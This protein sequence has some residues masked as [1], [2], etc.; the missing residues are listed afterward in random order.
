MD[1]PSDELAIRIIDR[2]L[3]ARL[4]D[5]SHAVRL[6]T[7]IAQGTTTGAE[8]RAAVEGAIWSAGRAERGD[9]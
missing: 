9:E 3:A 5:E 2:L 7:S 4:I 8:W 1:T 6:C